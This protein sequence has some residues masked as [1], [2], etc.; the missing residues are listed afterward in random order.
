M[1]KMLLYQILEQNADFLYHYNSEFADNKGNWTYDSLVNVLIS[2][3]DH[4][5][6]ERIYLLI[7]ALDESDM[8]NGERKKL[9]ESLGNLCKKSGNCVVKVFLASRPVNE[10]PDTMLAH[11]IYLHEHTRSDIAR[12]TS[13]LLQDLSVSAE[14]PDDIAGKIVDRAEGVFIWVHY[15]GKILTQLAQ[16]GCSGEDILQALE[17]LPSDLEK[18]YQRIL[19]KI[20]GGTPQGRDERDIRHSKTIFSYTLFAMRP[21]TI[22]ELSHVLAVYDYYRQ[23]TPTGSNFKHCIISISGME[24]RVVHCGQNLIGIGGSNRFYQL[25]DLSDEPNSIASFVETENENEIPGVQ[26]VQPMHQTVRNFLLLSS[27][28]AQLRIDKSIIHCEITIASYRYLDLFCQGPQNIQLTKDLE[29]W[30]TDNFEH[31]VRYIG[32]WEW[33]NYIVSYLPAH[34]RKCRPNEQVDRLKLQ[35]HN[36]LVACNSMR[37]LLAYWVNTNALLLQDQICQSQGVGKDST[38]LTCPKEPCTPPSFVNR[39]LPTAAKLRQFQV[40]DIAIKCGA[41]VESLDG[42]GQTMLHWIAEEGHEATARLLLDRG[43]DIKARTGDGETPLHCATK[44]VRMVLLLLDYGADIEA[45]NRYGRTPLHCAAQ[46]GHE[47]TVR[48]LLDRGAKIEAK[49]GN[50]NGWTSLHWAAQNGHEAIVRLLLDR[51]A[52]IRSRTG[53]GKTPLH[54]ATKQ[55]DMVLL[56]LN[57]GADI[58]AKDVSNQTP[59]Y[60]AV[61]LNMQVTVRL[62]LERGADTEARFKGRTVLHQAA[63][64]KGHEA[65]VRLLLDRGADIEAKDSGGYTPLRRAAQF[66]RKATVQLLRDHGATDFK[67]TTST[68]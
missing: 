56:L 47:T 62:L 3:G 51:G 35:V 30:T 2:L 61:M 58:E 1:L 50:G 19:D 40:V 34:L 41:H 67:V 64:E 43:A 15:V 25:N 22:N 39:I 33:I 52:E 38:D 23:E 26:P 18:I 53:D 13:S 17:K 24:R 68:P 16:N 54:C 4:P 49:D 9:V 48:L 66:D 37:S 14:I 63:M 12:Y 6:N 42:I 57:H 31:F 65:I 59:L 20:C 36:K 27:S 45:K 11:T 21:L 44:R 55:A 60:N 46:N 10:V 28:L 32:Q 7:D 29:L 5:V 8:G